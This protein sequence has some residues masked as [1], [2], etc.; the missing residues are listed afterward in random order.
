MILIKI[1]FEYKSFQNDF[2]PVV[3]PDRSV[4]P[5]TKSGRTLHKYHVK[6]VRAH[7]GAELGAWIGWADQLTRIFDPPMFF[8]HFYSRMRS[9]M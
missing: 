4:R 5:E 7:S 9:S 6:E 3:A 8:P 1:S 2:I